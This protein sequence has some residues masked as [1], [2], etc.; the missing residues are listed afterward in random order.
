MTQPVVRWRCVKRWSWCITR[1]RQ[2]E[3]KRRQRC[4]KWGLVPC[5][6]RQPDGKEEV[7]AKS[8]GR[9]GSGGGATTG[10]MQQPTGKQEVN[11]RGGVQEANW[12][13]GVSGQVAAERQED[14]RRRRCNM[15][16]CHG[17]Q[18]EAPAEPHPPPPPP[19]PPAGMVAPLSRSLATAAAATSPALSLSSA[20]VKSMHPPLSLSTPLHRCRC[21]PRRTHGAPF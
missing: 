2:L 19:F 12:R 4:D 18:P 1:Q 6:L 11:G 14:E 7:K 10:A 9:G 16:R 3:D 13:G 8:R 17:N 20:L 15:V 5:E 21:R